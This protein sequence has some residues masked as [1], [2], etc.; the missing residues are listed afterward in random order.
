MLTVYPLPLSGA[1]VKKA[2]NQ[3]VKYLSLQNRK[4]TIM[5]YST[6]LNR[7][8]SLEGVSCL[9]CVSVQIF[10]SLV[11]KMNS[12]SDETE[13]LVNIEEN[14]LKDF[15]FP[16]SS[17]VYSLNRVNANT[18]IKEHY[19]IDRDTDQVINTIGNGE[20]LDLTKISIWERRRDLKGYE[21]SA[22]TL[23]LSLYNKLDA[24][25]GQVGLTA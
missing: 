25:F 18:V 24:P 3:L 2:A 1:S 17:Q 20:S 12:Y 5:E 21:V 16:F 23:N 7:K 14:E 6:F 19:N 13:W 15:F 9:V 4:S 10:P 22:E 11:Q 8:I